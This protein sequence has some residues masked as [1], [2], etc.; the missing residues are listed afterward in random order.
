M[1]P[2]DDDSQMVDAPESLPRG[3][4]R[5][6][7]RRGRPPNGSMLFTGL[8]GSGIPNRLQ[9][10]QR[11]A[12]PTNSDSEV[13]TRPRRRQREPS[14]ESSA[15]ANNVANHLSIDHSDGLDEKPNDL[16]MMD[17][18]EAEHEPPKPYTSSLPTGLCYDVRMRYH[19]ELDP[20]K[21]R[22]DYHPEDPRRI[23]KIYQELCLA[24]LVKDDLL[25]NGTLIPNPLK[26]IPV[27]NVTESEVCLVHDKKHYDFMKSTSGGLMPVSEVNL[28]EKWL[29]SK[30]K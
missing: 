1:D 30:Q 26:R 3:L 4:P 16:M 7:E 19:C 12:T 28:E 13:S 15:L 22:L 17:E 20:P 29:T 27:R 23:F 9:D 5:G 6:N 2:S 11:Y 21:Q 25:N 24:G 10:P 8:P 18:S 14:R